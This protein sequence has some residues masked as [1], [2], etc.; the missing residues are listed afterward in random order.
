MVM[1]M[2]GVQA[3]RGHVQMRN[4]CVYTY[5]YIYI[6]VH[7]FNLYISIYIYLLYVYIYI[8]TLYTRISRDDFDKLGSYLGMPSCLQY[9]ED[10][11]QGSWFWKLKSRHPTPQKLGACR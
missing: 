4:V 11:I 6:S 2:Y 3:D 1:Y 10:T 7:K 9:L 5:I 8:Y